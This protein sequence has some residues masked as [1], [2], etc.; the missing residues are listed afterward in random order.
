ML[1][2]PSVI[3]FCLHIFDPL[4]PHHPPPVCCLDNHHTVVCVV[5]SYVNN[6]KTVQLQ[7]YSQS[8]VANARAF[9]SL[10]FLSS[11][12]LFCGPK[13]VTWPAQTTKGLGFRQTGTNQSISEF[14]LP[15]T[16]VLR[17][18]AWQVGWI[19]VNHM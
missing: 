2:P 19:L 7:H 11:H 10:C 15:H 16:S 3:S 13:Q 12:L 6:N 4:Y 1:V 5:G 14:G 8:A 17:L 18:K 9:S